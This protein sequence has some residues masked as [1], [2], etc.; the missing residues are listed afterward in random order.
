M[1]DDI[2]TGID[3]TRS[4]IEAAAE[5]EGFHQPVDAWT[6]LPDSADV[7]D[8]KKVERAVKQLAREKPFLVDPYNAP[9]PPPTPG[10]PGSRPHG[11]RPGNAI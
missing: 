7:S 11:P 3:E 1:V 5:R 9:P 4:M 10:H 6:C 8:E 2:E